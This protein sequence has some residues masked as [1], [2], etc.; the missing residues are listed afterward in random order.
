MCD[1]NEVIHMWYIC[2]YTVFKIKLAIFVGYI[3]I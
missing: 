3:G 2:Q 1:K